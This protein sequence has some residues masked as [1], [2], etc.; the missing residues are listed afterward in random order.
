MLAITD[1][2]L[3]AV[4][5]VAASGA[6]TEI[7]LPAKADFAPMGVTYLDS[8]TTHPTSLGAK[9][10]VEAYLEAR[11]YASGNGYSG[12][13]VG[14]VVL[15]RF[16]RLINA[17]PEEVCFV[18]NTSSAEHLVIGVLELF[19]APGRIVTDTLHFSGSYYL[20]DELG[21]RGIDVV[22]LTPKKE[23]IELADM[24]AA[25]TP[26]TRLIAL[27]LVSTVNGFQHDLR[28]VCE[29]AHAN[30]SLV[31]ADIVHAAGAVPVDV[32]A[33]G[34]DFAACSSFKWL[35]GDFGLGFLY[36]RKEI[37]GRL[38][39]AQFGYFQLAAW[40]AGLFPLSPPTD[41]STP[42]QTSADATGLF[43]GGSPAMA[44]LAQLDSSLE[45]ISTIGV[46]AIEAYRLP[47]LRRLESELPPLG[48]PLLTPV[49]SRSPFVVCS[50]TNAEVLSDRLRKARVKIGLRRDRFR[51]AP[52]VFNDQSDIDRL[53]EA[54]C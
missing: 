34:V 27:S 8:A 24:A 31:Y 37:I 5:I 18:P 20:Y 44:A 32:K 46:S 11:T 33:S 36:V 50:C 9:A 42:Y 40:Q 22:W 26:G 28:R 53:L 30:G 47:L 7:R 17:S 49:E 51:V 16:A 13:G 6:M 15:E 43:A 29:I 41:V 19:Q 2:A 25:A 1:D 45:Y 23:R 21:R 10:A 12:R 54:L 48:Y 39:R 38:Q 14:K 3:E 4:G 52:S 35:M